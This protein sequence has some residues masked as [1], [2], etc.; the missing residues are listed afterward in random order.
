[1]IQYLK[2]LSNFNID[3]NL[4]VIKSPIDE[5]K[6]LKKFIEKFNVWNKTEKIFDS[7]GKYDDM[8]KQTAFTRRRYD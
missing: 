2:V 3:N 7:E 6:T 8:T 5:Q 4:N 1:M